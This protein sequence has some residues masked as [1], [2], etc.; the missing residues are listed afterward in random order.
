MAAQG[1]GTVRAAKD[2]GT[3][4]VIIPTHNRS[5]YLR[6]AVASVLR[7]SYEN[8]EV[9]IVDDASTDDTPEVV[10]SVGDERVTYLRNQRNVG[11]NASRNRGLCTAVGEYIAFLD[12]DDYYIDPEKIVDQVMLLKHNKNVGFVGCGYYDVSIQA[13]RIPNIKGQISRDLLLSFSNIETSTILMRREVAEQAGY[14]DEKL[15][16]EQNR[17]FFYRISKLAG[18]DYLSRISVVKDVPQ[19]QITTNVRKKI[20]GYVFFHVKYARDIIR[21]PFRDTSFI[22]MKFLFALLFFLANS[23]HR[24][25]YTLPKLYEMMMR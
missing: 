12:D 4:S 18:F 8:I 13:E 11:A 7:Q 22:L 24:Q 21:L 6:R 16:S 14:L 19:F 2:E 9:I 1:K 20:L 5:A 17:D 10:T 23:I 3:V 15:P 25:H